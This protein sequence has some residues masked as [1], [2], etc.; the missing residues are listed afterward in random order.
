[1][2]WGLRL[3]VFGGV[4]LLC[5]MAHSGI[6]AVAFAL[7]WGPNYPFFGAAMVGALRLPR[8]LVPVHSIEPTVYRWVGVDIIKWIVTTRA[9]LMLVGLEPPRKLSSRHAFLDRTEQVTKGAEICHGASFVF[10]SCIALCCLAIGGNSA[11]VW[12]LAFNIAL[13][14]YPIMLQRSIRWRVHRLRANHCGVEGESRGDRT[15]MH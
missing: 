8:F 5:L 9:W 4:A 6:P 7:V 11:A 15:S 13:N 1:M 12:I 14:G 3:L 2:V 10:A